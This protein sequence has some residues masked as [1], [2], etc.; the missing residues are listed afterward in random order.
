M[1]QFEEINLKRLMDIIFKRISFIIAFTLIAG[2]LAFV[3][4]E[5][6]LSPEYESAVTM[7]VIN[8]KESTS[9][10]TYSTDL[11]TSKMLVDTYKVIVKSDTVLNEVC[12]KLADKGMTGYTAERLRGGITASAVDET[13]IFEVK[14]RTTDPKGSHLIANVIADVAPNVIKDFVEASSV[15]IIDYA[16]YGEKVYPNVQKNMI[17]G[18]LIGLFLSCLFV[19]LKEIFDTRIKSE[20]DLEQWF[21]YPMLAVI[22]DISAS[23]N[24]RTSGYYRRYGDDMYEYEMKEVAKNGEKSN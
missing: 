10:K 8:E 3:Y 12:R 14:V 2:I 23:Q 1:E 15:K 19:I 5:V 13:E 21:E 17:L 6:V 7:Y 24:K 20:D 4:S 16:L 18:L 22:P 9:Q 11:Q